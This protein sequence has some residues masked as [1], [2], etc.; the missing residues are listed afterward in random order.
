MIDDFRDRERV[1]KSI[2]VPVFSFSNLSIQNQMKIGII[3]IDVEGAEM[4]VIEGLRQEIE[5]HRPFILIE[6]LPVYN[7]NNKPRL[8]RQNR[9]Q[10]ILFECGYSIF[11]IKKDDKQFFELLGIDDFGIHSDLN[12][13]E[14]ILSPNEQNTYL[15]K[16]LAN[17]SYAQ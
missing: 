8:N 2:N 11:R 12:M 13:C 5:S 16:T 15:N 14:Y 7:K 17:N 3:K 10:K 1:K 6:I 9:I 4:E